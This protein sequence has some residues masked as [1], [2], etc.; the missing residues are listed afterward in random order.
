VGGYVVLLVVEVVGGRVVVVVVGGR[1]VVVVG[2]SVVVVGG[3]VVVVVVGG[4]VVDVVVSDGINSPDSTPESTISLY[5]GSVV[6]VV[7]ISSVYV[8]AIEFESLPRKVMVLPE[9]RVHDA[10]YELNVSSSAIVIVLSF[11]LI[12]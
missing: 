10:G 3:R 11:T 5:S 6:V 12:S 8:I 2:A 7:V 4:R 9:A 1:V